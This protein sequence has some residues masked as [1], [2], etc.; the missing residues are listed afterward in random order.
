[1]AAFAK[2][3]F[4]AGNYAAFR[5][6]YP[7]SLY[8]TVLNYHHGPRDLCVDL[9]CG[10]GVVTRHL[11]AAFAHVI[12]TDPSKGMIDQARSSTPKE[13]YPNVEYKEAKAESSPFLE[14]G[15]VDMV[16]AGQAAHWFD[17]ERLFP[18]M[19]RIVRTNGT[20]AFWGY[21]DHVFVDYP[22]ATKVL[23]DYAY[24]NDD[25][26]LGPYWSQPGRSIVEDKLR[27]IK[28]P[29]KDWEDIQRI[30]YEPAT[31]GP[32]SGQGTLFVSKRMKL[33]ECMSYI[34]TWS[35]F[36]GWQEKYRQIKRREEGGEGDV[37]D[38]MF[39]E[40]VNAEEDWRKEED[41]REKEVEIEWG[42]G[43]LLAR[44]R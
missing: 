38:E 8:N 14:D 19:K 6:T 28:P 16:V 37:V 7:C 3:T 10:H 34:R 9:G 12:G 39:D 26:Q 42:S 32:K 25:R 13:E 44:R 43:L 21:K 24:T 17:Y 18:E 4:S 11:S 33:G 5:P 41:W 36:H 31:K 22:G 2:S 30:E 23:N 20:M 35:S 15:S 29:T 27:A 1:M 40:M